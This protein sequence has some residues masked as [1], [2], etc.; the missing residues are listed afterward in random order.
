[1]IETNIFLETILM[2]T[3]GAFGAIFGSY[4][5]L[6]SHRIPLDESCFGRYFGSKSSCPKCKKV[7]KTRELIPIINWIITLGRC[8]DCKF[9]IPRSHLFLEVSIAIL[10]IINFCLFRFSDEFIIFSLIAT[11]AM[12]GLVVDFKHNI[13]PNQVL[14]T[15]LTIGLAGRA[16]EDGTIINI[17]Y[18]GAFGLILSTA[19]YKTFFGDGKSSFLIIKEQALAYSIFILIASICLPTISFILYFFTV[20]LILS[21]FLLFGNFSRNR[22]P[23]IGAVI[24]I[25]F[26]WL[27]IYSPLN[28]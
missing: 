15:I 14:Y 22:S 25:P 11:A 19:F 7:L 20:I 10:F 4:A 13:L 8:S 1:M 3:A 12:V 16:L 6:F 21:I 5:T 9:K 2:I 24:I 27:L 28:F 23:R 17:I 18:S 26:I